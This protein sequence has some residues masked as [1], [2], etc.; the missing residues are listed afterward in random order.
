MKKFSLLALTFLVASFY[1]NCQDTLRL[2]N[3]RVI[4]VSIRDISEMKISYQLKNAKKVSF[5]ERT[6]DEI[7]S[8]K[9]E[10]QKEVQVY[11]YN[12][13]RGNFYTIEEMKQFILGEQ[14]ADSYH[15]STFTKISAVAVGSVAGYFMADGGGVIA[16]SPIVYS[17]V[18]MI[19][20]VHLQR[21]NYNGDL[22]NIAP[23]RAGYSRVSKGKRFLNNLAYSAI[24]MIGSFVLFEYTDASL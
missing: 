14:H 19:P 18:M 16:A 17:T 2:M 3:G 8:F 4:E 23:Y 22:R 20:K 9:K 13:E 11:Q 12:V 6:T 10:G 7:F 15:R 5:Q 21:N 24:G 1:A